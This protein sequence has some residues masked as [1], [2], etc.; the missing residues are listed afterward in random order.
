LQI[1]T[2]KIPIGPHPVMSTT[3]PGI[4]AVSAVWN[5]F[6]MGSMIP[7]ISYGVASSRCQTFVAGIAM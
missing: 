5:A 1:P 7:P 4:S 6:P 2:A 3:D